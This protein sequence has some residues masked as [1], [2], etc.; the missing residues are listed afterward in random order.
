MQSY[1]LYVPAEYDSKKIWPVILIFDPA[2]R[3][4]TGV[5][6]FVEAG[7]RYGFILA[8]SNNS[9]NGPQNDNFISATAMFQDISERFSVDQKRIYA[10]GFSG[11]SRFAMSFAIAEKRIAGVIGC[12]A[13]LPN[14]GNILPTNPGFLYYGMAGNRDMNY[15]EMYEL[16]DLLSKKNGIISYLRTFPGGHQW[17]S[18]NLITEAVEWL[19]LQSMNRKILPA[20]PT[21]VSKIEKKTENLIHSSLSA[22]N[23]TDAIR[24]MRSAARDFRGTP[25]E[26]GVNKMLADAEKSPEYKTAVRKWNRMISAEQQSR[27]KYVRYLGAI[28]SSASLPDS[29]TSWWKKEAV[30]LVRIRQ[31]GSPENSQMA[32]RLLNFISIACSGQGTSFYRNNYFTQAAFLFE[33]CTFSDG[34]NPDNY[35]NLARSLAQSGKV[36]ESVAALSAA[37]D[38]GFTSR[39]KVESDPA[40]V[41]IRNDARYRE[42]VRKMK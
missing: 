28:F 42:L 29:A 17:P 19:I 1:A 10:S 34:E 31:K 32:S 16:H 25:F 22:G 5:E 3:G 6:S 8:C 38:H 37:V 26:S 24:Y 7:R 11:G 2:A 13:G 39:K 27:E 21:F 36:K 20:D 15:L 18:S 14:D 40:F 30:T 12:G 9:R 35:Y 23:V 4:R 33:I 41:A